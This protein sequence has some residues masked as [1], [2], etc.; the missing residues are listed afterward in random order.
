M[1]SPDIS[2]Y[3]YQVVESHLRVYRHDG[4]PVVCDWDTLQAIKN[5]A[6]G[7][8]VTAIEIFPAQDNVV[9]EVNYRHFWAIFNHDV[10]SA[11]PSIGEPHSF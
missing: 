5:E 8:D 7:E 6:L 2:E 4:C 11:L 10:L 9:D 3:G 1:P